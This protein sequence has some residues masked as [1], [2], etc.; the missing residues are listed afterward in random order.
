MVRC[1]I[2]GSDDITDLVYH[3]GNYKC[4]NCGHLFKVGNFDYKWY[5]DV[6]YWYKDD[7]DTLRLYQK[8]FFAVF[9]DYFKNDEKF[10]IYTLEIGAADG[11]FLY[12]VHNR[13]PFQHL[14][15]NELQDNCRKAYNDFIE[16]KIILD[17]TKAEDTAVLHKFDNIVLNDVIEHFDDVHGAMDKL[18][19]F[20]VDGGR[21]MFITNNGDFLNAHNELIYH[22]EH[23]NIFS[24]KSWKKF[25][26]DY[27]VKELLHFNSPQGLSFIVL[28]K[29]KE[30]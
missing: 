22:Y 14:F 20:L 24:A 17:F 15:Y 3:Q 13:Y 29:I 10:N 23:L 30:N 19:D 21:L 4:N 12:H 2:C 27:P 25:I 9:E 28:E 16:K 18:V 7:P 11:D 1:P 26:E 8:M 6:D 5:T